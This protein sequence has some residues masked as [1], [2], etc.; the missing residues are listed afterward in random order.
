MEDSC[1]N[2]RRHP[3]MCLCITVRPVKASEKRA[4]VTAKTRADT[5]A[6]CPQRRRR[7]APLMR[8]IRRPAW[9]APANRSR[10]EWRVTLRAQTD[11]LQTMDRRAA[12][13]SAHQSKI[14]YRNARAAALSR[15]AR[16]R[17]SMAGSSFSA[18]M[19]S[20]PSAC[21]GRCVDSFANSV[22]AYTAS[23]VTIS[24]VKFAKAFSIAVC[25]RCCRW[26][27]AAARLRIAGTQSKPAARAAKTFANCSS[28]K[29]PSSVE[30]C[31]RSLA[32]S[33][34]GASW[35]AASL[36]N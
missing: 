1:G 3:H 2:G 5:T 32:P 19:V 21:S 23:S 7:I 12:C 28:A 29:A 22:F 27:R 33:R 36:E 18:R 14:A 20:W 35:R 17:T 10:G 26:N 16:C 31:A 6:T 13:D 24:A 25:S 8:R 11:L 15:S 9:R 30:C 4:A 34:S